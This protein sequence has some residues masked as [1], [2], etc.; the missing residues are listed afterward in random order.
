VVA[1]VERGDDCHGSRGA[2]FNLDAQHPHEYRYQRA[3]E[4]VEVVKKLW[5]SFEDD[6]FLRDKASVSSSTGI[7][8]MIPTMSA[9]SLKFAGR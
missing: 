9:N 4:H 2:Y 6:A 7:R 1:R 3:T 5:D 8:C